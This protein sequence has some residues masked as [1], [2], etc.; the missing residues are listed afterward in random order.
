MKDWLNKLDDFLKLSGK[1]LPH[2]VRVVSAEMAK[3]TASNEYDQF[4]ERIQYELSPVEIH[5]FESFE[6]TQKKL[7][8]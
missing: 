7:K 4:K 3:L 5:F 6:E 2:H 1:E 8:K